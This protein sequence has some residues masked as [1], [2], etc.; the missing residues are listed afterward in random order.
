MP[1][2]LEGNP[3]AGLLGTQFG[4]WQS[5]GFD[6]ARCPVRNIL[7][8]L[9]DKWTTLVLVALAERA[10]R[11]SELRRALPDISKRML[12]QTLRELERDG[13]ITRRVFPTKPPSVEYALAARGQSVLT[14]LANLIAW[15]EAHFEEIL[16]ARQVFDAQAGS[17]AD[18]LGTGLI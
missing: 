3:P 17:M 16:A 15:S 9:G 12:T 1:R 2:L 11:F 7:D 10:H 18:A 6:P 14:P 5:R 4:E 8:R 13:F